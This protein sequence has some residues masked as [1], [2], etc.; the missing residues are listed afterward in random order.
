[1]VWWPPFLWSIVIRNGKIVWK[2]GSHCWYFELELEI[3][4]V[5]VQII[6]QNSK[7]RWLLWGIPQWKWPWGCFCHFLL[8]WL[9]CQRF[10]RSSEVPYRS[11]RLSKMLFVCYSL[12]DSQ[13][14]SI[15]NNEKRLVTYLLGHLRR[16]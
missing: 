7:K 16:S 8:L 11:N 4:G 1:M 10:W 3:S 9:W 15:N 13:H 14:I 5:F 12:M 6:H 2:H